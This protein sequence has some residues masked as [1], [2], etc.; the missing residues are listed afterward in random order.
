M[1]PSGE[2]LERVRPGM[3]RVVARGL[4]VVAVD[5]VGVCNC[6]RLY[7]SK[8]VYFYCEAMINGHGVWCSS[9]HV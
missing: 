3:S 1:R 6:A 5:E 7:V 4:G 9:M 2:T 8:Y